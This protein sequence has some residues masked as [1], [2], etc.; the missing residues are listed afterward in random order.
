VTK[1]EQEIQKILQLLARR[2]MK[3]DWSKTI[4]EMIKLLKAKRKLEDRMDYAELMMEILNAMTF[5]L[6]GWHQWGNIYR[7][8][9]LTKEEYEEFIPKL[10]AIAIKWLELDKALTAKKEAEIP[11]EVPKTQY[12]S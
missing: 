9:K 5:S 10:K 6:N 8:N 1:K 4:G 12:V 2:K 7:L 3:V 11:K